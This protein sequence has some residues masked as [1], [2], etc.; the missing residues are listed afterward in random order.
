MERSY[1]NQMNQNRDRDALKAKRLLGWYNTIPNVIWSV[2]NLVPISVFCYTLLD[3]KLLYVFIVISL[4]P[5]FFP[6]SFFDK[7]QLGKTTLTYKKLGVAFINKFTQ[8]GVIVNSFIRKKFPGYKAIRYHPSSIKKLMQQ[9]YI[10]EK[11]HF[12]LFV[13][14]SLTTLY[15]VSKSYWGWVAVLCITN[16]LY[17]I[18]PNLL[19][20]Y[21][22]LKLRLHARK[23]LM[24]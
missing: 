5:L 22:R 18:Y 6:N 11:F 12:T 4:L 7:I 19:Q 9:T 13:F 17:N 1:F 3:R 10:Y 15:A 14:F 8:N 24:D 2:L 21:I 23:L 16:M 20:Q